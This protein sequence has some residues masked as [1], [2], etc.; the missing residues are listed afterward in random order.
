[1]ETMRL[2]SERTCCWKIRVVDCPLLLKRK[3]PVGTVVHFDLIV[4]TLTPVR[5]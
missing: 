2:A 5:A 3:L 4:A 1:M